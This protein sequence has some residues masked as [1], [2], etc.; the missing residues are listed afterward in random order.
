MWVGNSADKDGCLPRKAC[1]YIASVGP[2]DLKCLF[3]YKTIRIL[4]CPGKANNFA[5]KYADFL[6]LIYKN[7]KDSRSITF[8]TYNYTKGIQKIDKACLMPLGSK[9]RVEGF[10]MVLKH[11]ANSRKEN[12]HKSTLIHPSRI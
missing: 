7:T 1:R 6:H 12:L 3:S 11:L 5:L 2:N 4:D 10:R 8:G 9:I